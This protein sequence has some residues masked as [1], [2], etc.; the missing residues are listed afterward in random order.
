MSAMAIFL[1]G[2]A[3]STLCLFGLYFTIAEIS[4]LGR[5]SDAR[6]PARGR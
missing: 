4:R 5:D 6:V 2:L 1:V 3:V